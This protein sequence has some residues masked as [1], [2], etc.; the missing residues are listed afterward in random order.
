VKDE[1][2]MRAQRLC[3]PKKNKKGVKDEK[4]MRA[5]SDG[6]GNKA[7]VHSLFS[8]CAHRVMWGGNE[9]ALSLHAPTL[10]ISPPPVRVLIFTTQVLSHS[11]LSELFSL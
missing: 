1:K 2:L 5:Q 7:S 4:L 8:S 10:N 11:S 3:Q 6:G 9:A